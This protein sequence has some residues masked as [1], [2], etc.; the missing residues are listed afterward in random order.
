MESNIRQLSGSS[1]YISSSGEV[2]S[3]KPNGLKRLHQTVNKKTHYAQ[4]T[5]SLSG[6]IHTFNVHRLVAENFI[7]DYNYQGS[8]HT[9]HL[10]GTR[11][12]SSISNLRWCTNEDNHNFKKARLN[13]KKVNKY[14]AFKHKG[15]KHEFGVVQQWK[16]DTL[17][18]E[19]PTAV[20]AATA[21]EGNHQGIYQAIKGRCGT[22]KVHT[23]KGYIWKRSTSP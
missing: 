5:L 20:A 12:N 14:N 2:Y 17:I 15:K 7:T 13:H 19:Y 21:V 22:Q 9:D 6:H 4:V 18:A 3:S 11:T 16:G 23:Y 8:G 10:D 1:Y